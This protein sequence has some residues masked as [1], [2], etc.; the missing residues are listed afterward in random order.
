MKC[1]DTQNQ[2]FLEMSKTV[3]ALQFGVQTDAGTLYFS[4]FPSNMTAVFANASPQHLD[5]SCKST[6]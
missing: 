6:K 4:S 5:L 2:E 1:S 3:Q